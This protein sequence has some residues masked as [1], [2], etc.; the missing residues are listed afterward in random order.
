MLGPSVSLESRHLS[1]ST[2]SGLPPALPKFHSNLGVVTVSAPSSKTTAAP[3]G[4]APRHSAAAAASTAQN[5][6]SFT[7]P[8]ESP[9]TPATVSRVYGKPKG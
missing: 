4:A 5:A 1:P 2:C 3:A 9:D 8:D 7:E 6:H